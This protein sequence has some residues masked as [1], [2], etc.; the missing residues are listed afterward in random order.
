[1]NR[2][3][4]CEILDITENM[5]GD[6]DIVKKKYRMQAL[7][8]HP[9]KNKAEDASARFMEIHDAY[10]FLSNNKPTR[11]SY[12]DL[13][14]EFTKSAMKDSH[15]Y[16]PI[17]MMLIGKIAQLCEPKIRIIL[18]SLDKNILIEIHKLL[19][20]YKNIFHISESVIEEIKRMISE[21]TKNDEIIYIHPSIDDLMKDNI[22][23]L[24]VGHH[25]YMIPLWHHELIYD[26]SG[27]DIYVNCV[28]ELPENISIDENN[29]IHTN[30]YYN[31]CDILDK[32]E[33]CV[34]IGTRECTIKCT[35]LKMVRKQTITFENCGI[36]MIHR[37]KIYDVTKRGNIHITI[38]IVTEK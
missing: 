36:P 32:D 9:D 4:A 11:M 22:Y 20:V 10:E 19:L 23:K 5:A 34:N 35:D 16:A 25:T 12:A 24:I 2:Q 37:R 30:I 6:M 31:I 17:Y 28:P 33:I 3:R 18:Q 29:N 27:N 14:S 15:I 26:N 8:F 7:I 21:S 38:H 13:L 1:M